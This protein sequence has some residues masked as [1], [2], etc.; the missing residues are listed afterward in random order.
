M[1]TQFWLFSFIFSLPFS[2][3]DIF[4]ESVLFCKN[5]GLDF[6][7]VSTL[8]E[9]IMNQKK[10]VHDLL[11]TLSKHSLRANFVPFEYLNVTHEAFQPTLMVLA[12]RKMLLNDQMF[13]KCLDK[14]SQ[15]FIKRS[16]LVIIEEMDENEEEIL[17]KQVEFQANRNY[18]FYIIFKTVNQYKYKMAFSLRNT[19]RV[20]FQSLEFN[21]YGMI[22]EDY[23]LKGIQIVSNSMTW[24]P[25]LMLTNCNDKGKECK[26]DG[27][28]NDLMNMAGQM[29]NFSWTSHAQIGGNWGVIPQNGSWT[30]ILGSIVNGH[31]HLSMSVWLYT[32]GVD[33]Y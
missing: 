21:V 12:S 28:L 33:F 4:Y 24:F 22:K 8:N 6:L 15:H 10:N 25:I 2:K 26:F 9:D 32:I 23:N 3:C 13:S 7:A 20:L 27:Y 18:Y 14:I 16:L 11:S 19:T 29:A 5:N 31:F 1:N 30:G 17:K